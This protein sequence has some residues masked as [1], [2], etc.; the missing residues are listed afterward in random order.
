[1]ADQDPIARSPIPSASPE[2]I[3]AGWA[4][5]GRRS[6]AALTVTDC[7]ALA[8][9]VTKALPDGVV[10]RSLGVRLGRTA[11]QTWSCEGQDVPVLV[12]GSAPGEWTVLGPPGTQGWLVDA[13][14]VTAGTATS[15]ELVTVL[16]LT[17]GR[18][19]LRLTGEQSAELLAKECAV[20][21]SDRMCPDGAALRCAVAKVATDVV[22]DDRDGV[23]SY[24]VHCERSAGRY[25]FDSLLDAGE[26]FGAEVDGLVGP[27]V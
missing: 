18:A 8:K 5:S 2:V 21:L 20:D 24:L 23:R 14:A 15:D 17:H 27:G 9:A 7:T 16:D 12:V 25:L 13:L 3:A 11:R 22:R 26:E 10:A 1:M 4:V 6:D 19:M